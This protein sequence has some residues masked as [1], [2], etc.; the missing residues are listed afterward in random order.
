M[1][2]ESQIGVDAVLDHGEPHLLQSVDLGPRPRLVGH[3]GQGGAAP[4]R[5]RF[6]RA[7]FDAASNR[8]AWNSSRPAAASSSKRSTSSWAGATRIRYPGFW[9]IKDLRRAIPSVDRAREPCAGSRRGPGGRARRSRVGPRPTTGP[10]ARRVETTRLAWRSRSA[11]RLRSRPW[12][13]GI[14]DAAANE[15]E[16]AEQPE[17]EIGRGPTNPPHAA[18]S[19][20][21]GTTRRPCGQR[22]GRLEPIMSRH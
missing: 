21:P 12:P 7:S 8:S 15:L 13:T 16:R 17:L 2:T 14:G 4:H 3:V 1:S 9:V 18:G 10:R 5:Q 11:S 22:S 19:R 6:G 20:L